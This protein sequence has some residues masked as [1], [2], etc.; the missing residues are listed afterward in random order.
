MQIPES[1]APWTTTATPRRFLAAMPSGDRLMPMCRAIAA[2]SGLTSAISA[3][4]ALEGAYNRV[5]SGK[6][7]T[8]G[9]SSTSDSSSNG[10]T[11]SGCSLYTNTHTYRL[12]SGCEEAENCNSQLVEPC[13]LP[14]PRNTTHLH[15]FYLATTQI[16]QY[17]PTQR[18]PTRLPHGHVC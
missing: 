17:T 5:A 13:N 16:L 9:I 1:G 3:A 10:S 11:L 18:L 2:D 4:S 12:L 15:E 8:E 6:L 14:Q 7:G